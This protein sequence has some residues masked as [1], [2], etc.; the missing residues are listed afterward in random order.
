M[1]LLTGLSHLSKMNIVHRDLKP[2]NILFSKPVNINILDQTNTNTT[3][4][5]SIDNFL[6]VEQPLKKQIEM[7]AESVKILD[8]GLAAYLHNNHIYSKCGTPGFLAPELFGTG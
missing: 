5:S 3:D 7:I 4:H 6:K 2:F 8:F 1:G